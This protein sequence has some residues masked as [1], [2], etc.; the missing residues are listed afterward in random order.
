MSPGTT[1]ALQRSEAVS[2]RVEGVEGTVLGP[3]LLG[4]LVAKAAARTEISVDPTADRHCIDFVVL[5]GLVAAADVG[6]DALSSKDRSRLR[7]MHPYC[8][9]CD[10]AMVLEGATE[11]LDRLERVLDR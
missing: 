8:R 11:S 5:A 9:G 4:A 6:Q 1:Q 10:E 2:V 3:D 7:R